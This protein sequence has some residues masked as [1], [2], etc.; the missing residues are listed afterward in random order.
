MFAYVQHVEVHWHFAG[1]LESWVSDVLNVKVFKAEQVFLSSP[2]LNLLFHFVAHP[3]HSQP[4]RLKLTSTCLRSS[5]P[6]AD[7]GYLLRQ[8]EFM[9]KPNLI[10]MQIRVLGSK[11]Y[12]CVSHSRSAH[13]LQ[14]TA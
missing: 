7:V 12:V 2:L 6:F 9:R 14:T 13:I 4:I 3:L 10:G 1:I 5:N 8:S 11:Y